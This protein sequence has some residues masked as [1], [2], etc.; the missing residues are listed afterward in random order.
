MSDNGSPI[1]FYHKNPRQITV[2][3]YE[4][5][6]RWL[7]EL[8]DLSGIIHDL[9]SNQIIGGNQRGRVFD[10]NECEIVLAEEY[11]Q[12]DE[13]GTVAI[14]Y[15]LWK[16]YRYGYR[17]VRWNEEQCEMAN[18]VANKAGGEW[19]FDIL[20]NVFEVDD[21]L[22]WGFGDRELQ[23]HGIGDLPEFK[24]YDESIADEVEYHECP[25]CGHKWP[26]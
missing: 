18:I 17:Q 21:L 20:A 5:L 16:G 4:N 15:V 3:Q 7:E 8:G 22:K 25:E 26:K 14:G 11:D 1:E 6:E 13:Q 23:I 19:D 9:N 24:E 12:P 2:Q 10:I